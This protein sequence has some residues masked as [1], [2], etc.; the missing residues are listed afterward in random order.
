ML[1]KRVSDYLKGDVI[2]KAMSFVALILIGVWATKEDIAI[3][4]MVAFTAEMI[5]VFITFG[6]DSSMIKFYRDHP[7]KDVFS[8][9]V[10]QC[11]LNVLVSAIVL[12]FGTLL[13]SDGEHQY[14]SDNYFYIITF[15]LFISIGNI[16]RAHLVSLNESARVK[17]YSIVSGATNLSGLV[18]YS[19]LWGLTLHAIIASRIV[20]L[21]IYSILFVYLLVKLT[22]TSLIRL[23]LSKQMLRYSF[24]LLI[25]TMVGTISVYLSR[26]VLAGYVSTYELGIF[27]FFIMI[28]AG[29]SVIL[30]SFNQAWFPHL[31]DLHKNSGDEAIINEVNLRLSGAVRVSCYYIASSMIAYLISNHIHL[32][33]NE[34]YNYRHVAFILVDSLVFGVFYIIINPIVYIKAQTTY[35]TYASVI[36]LIVNA[37]LTIIVVE[38]F[39]VF[40][41]SLSTVLVSVFSFSLYCFFSQQ[42]VHRRLLEPK[43]IISMLILTVL[44]TVKYTYIYHIT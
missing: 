5:A 3:F 15:A 28:L 34:Y 18:I 41:A 36:L 1:R 8:T 29:T 10:L 44:M 11:G 25:S 21:L 32:S 30:H 42:A 35:V 22:D 7:V 26:I 40:G 33:F 14:I 13:Y 16:T 6:A 27:S 39:G 4:N 12:Y 43:I 38:K 17:W 9:Y 24:P 37:I 31:F 2:A 20:S 23:N 19:F